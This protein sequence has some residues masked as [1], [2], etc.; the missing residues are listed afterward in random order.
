MNIIEAL[1]KGIPVKTASGNEVSLVG[2]IGGS[3]PAP[4][5]VKIKKPKGQLMDSEPYFMENYHPCGRY[6]PP[7]ST[8]LDLRI[9]Y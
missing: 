8:S 1:K 5:V 7:Y 6:N 3:V 2:I 9:A 4:I